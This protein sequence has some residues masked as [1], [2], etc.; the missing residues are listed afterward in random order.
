MKVLLVNKFY[1]DVGGVETVVRQ[2][3]QD[4]ERRHE[5]KVC[6]LSTRSNPT[7]ECEFKC[8]NL[9][10][11]PFNFR[12]MHWLIKRASDFDVVH[13]HMPS[14]DAT[15]SLLIWSILRIN[16]NTK[17]FIT[18]HAFADNRSRLARILLYFFQKKL[19]RKASVVITTSKPLSNQVRSFAKLINHPKVI[20]LTCKNPLEITEKCLEKVDAIKSDVSDFIR[21]NRK[22]ALYFGRLGSYKGIDI[23]IEAASKLA[24]LDTKILIAGPGRISSEGK[25]LSEVNRN[26]IF[27][28]RFLS[29]D[30]KAALFNGAEFFILPSINNGEA[31]G[32]S[33]LEAMSYGLPVINT[34]LNTGVP[35]VSK[36]M[37][38]GVTVEPGSVEELSAAIRLLALDEKLRTQ[39]GSGAIR[40]YKKLFTP[41]SA[42]SRILKLYEGE[43]QI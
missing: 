41:E 2:N 14:P 1:H 11:V 39:L 23:L 19:L 38:S 25:R 33:Q 12:R 43:G 32:I 16:K 10:G 35:W 28:N 37:I 13:L 17:L 34:K 30:E 26:I 36:H 42:R 9:F 6:F 22:F 31:F 4:L 5:C 18:Y 40:R 29:E 20:P 24:D 27:L 8:Y 15:L 7:S 21:D 3:L